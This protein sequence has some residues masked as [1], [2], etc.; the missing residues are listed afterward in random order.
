MINVERR[1]RRDGYEICELLLSIVLKWDFLLDCSSLK[2]VYGSLF[3]PRGGSRCGGVFLPS[4]FSAHNEHYYCTLW[5][6][7]EGRKESLVVY[8][9]D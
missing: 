6:R 1:R 5:R 7:K 9:Y 8:Q 2:N 4:P 3:H